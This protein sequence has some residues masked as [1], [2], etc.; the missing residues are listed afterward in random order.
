MTIIRSST[1]TIIIISRPQQSQ[2]RKPKPQIVPHKSEALTQDQ[3]N[4]LMI[5]WWPVAGGHLPTGAGGT[6]P[7]S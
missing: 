6:R 7:S 2:T 1:T 5:V 4:E 3:K